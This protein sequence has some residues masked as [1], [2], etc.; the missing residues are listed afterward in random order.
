MPAYL[1][2][3]C[4][5]S[6]RTSGDKCTEVHLKI[7]ALVFSVYS[8]GSTFVVNLKAD[9]LKKFGEWLRIQNTRESKASDEWQI[10]RRCWVEQICV[11]RLSSEALVKPQRSLT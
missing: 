4:S 2:R 5:R 9:R 3:E 10:Q 7:R 11:S 8:P 6:R 1:P